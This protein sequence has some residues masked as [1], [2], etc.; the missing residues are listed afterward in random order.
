[1][2]QN[3]N[4]FANAY[5]ANSLHLMQATVYDNYSQH[6]Y[7]SCTHHYH[8]YLQGFVLCGAMTAEH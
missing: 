6:K 7:L 2:R 5:P 4:I 8:H 1:M 3:K